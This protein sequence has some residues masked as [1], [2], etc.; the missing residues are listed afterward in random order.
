[1]DA[2]WNAGRSLGQAQNNHLQVIAQAAVGEVGRGVTHAFGDLE[3]P[4]LTE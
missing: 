2:Q 1:M 4:L 3:K